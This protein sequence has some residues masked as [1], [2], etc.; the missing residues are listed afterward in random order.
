MMVENN[1]RKRIILENQEKERLEDIQLQKQAIK[2]SEDLEHARAEDFKQKA[3]V[4]SNMIQNSQAKVQ[5][6][7][8][9]NYETEMKN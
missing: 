3:D 8:N 9:K 5:D 2:M 1:E 6:I 7:K 4:I